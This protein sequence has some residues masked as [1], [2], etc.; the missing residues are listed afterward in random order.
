MK[1]FLRGKFIAIISLIKRIDRPQITAAQALKKSQ[2][3]CKSESI[4]R[5]IFKSRAKINETDSGIQKIE[6]TGKGSWDEES[7]ERERR[8][9]SK[10]DQGTICI[11]PTL[12]C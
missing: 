9:E 4:K 7:W 1:A 12:S 10:N 8:R 6:M 11:L 3:Q 2:E 5:K